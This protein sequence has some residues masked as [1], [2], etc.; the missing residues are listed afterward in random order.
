MPWEGG[1]VSP[2]LEKLALSALCSTSLWREFAYS[3]PS[4]VLKG[5][6]HAGPTASLTSLS[7]SL[8]LPVAPE[9]PT[10]KEK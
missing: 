2:F 10:T 1:W 5:T 4:P 3:S 9:P 7:A 8:A 6:S